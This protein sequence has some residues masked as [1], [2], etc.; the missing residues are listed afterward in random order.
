M[1]FVSRFM[2]LVR[3]PNLIFIALTQALFHY[4]I[5]YNASL[6]G[7]S[8]LP[9]L[10]HPFLF[11]VLCLASV[12]IAGAGYII[13]DYFDINID[14]INK[15]Q[16]LI[17]DNG[18]SRRHGLIWHLLLNLAG[19][20]LSAWVSMATRNPLILAGNIACVLLLWVYSTTYK[21]KPLIGNLLIAVLT[22]WVILV[23]I[24]AE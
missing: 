17:L 18:I 3:W 23:L 20:A 10:L 13:N 6:S 16:R 19:L 4:C 12:L 14:R 1:Q 21:R 22:G 2:R 5:V 11:W 9:L 15:P 8:S 7:K 24:V